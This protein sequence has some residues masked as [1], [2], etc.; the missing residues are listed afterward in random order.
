MP[1]QIF[2][3]VSTFDFEVNRAERSH[4]VRWLAPLLAQSEG[5]V[6]FLRRLNC[7]CSQEEARA[8]QVSHLCFPLRDLFTAD[9]YHCRGHTEL[10]NQFITYYN[11]VFGLPA[12]FGVQKVW[13]TAPNGEIRHPAAGGRAGWYEAFLEERIAS[14]ALR[15]R[16]RNVRRMLGTEA[17]VLL[18]ADSHVILVECK[19]KGPPSAEQYDRQQMMGETLARRL[20]KDF[21]FGM[22][23]ASKRDPRFARL[24]VPYVQW[25]EMKEQLAEMKG[26]PL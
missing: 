10:E 6:W 2:Q 18:L 19:Y 1:D 25:S 7:P 8:A 20:E 4:Q 26:A 16:A 13:R 24:D 11:D 14:E 9:Y 5:R 15:I 22:V 12:G 21:Y 23:V 17:D 3:P